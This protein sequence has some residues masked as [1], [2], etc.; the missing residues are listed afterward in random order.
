[1]EWF[2]RKTSSH[3]NRSCTLLP[4]LLPNAVGQAVTET[5]GERSGAQV[6]RTNRDI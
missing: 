3:Q 5:D 6:I 2:K 4:K 1:M